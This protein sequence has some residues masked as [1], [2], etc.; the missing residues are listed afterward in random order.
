MTANPARSIYSLFAAQ[1]A[2]PQPPLPFLM[3]HRRTSLN[4]VRGPTVEDRA[5]ELASSP[6]ACVLAHWRTEIVGLLEEHRIPADDNRVN[7][8]LEFRCLHRNH[9]LAGLEI[10]ALALQPERFDEALGV[11]FFDPFMRALNSTDYKMDGGGSVRAKLAHSAMRDRERSAWVAVL[12]ATT[13]A[14]VVRRGHAEGRRHLL[15]LRQR[16]RSLA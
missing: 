2:S 12:R 6:E 10:V 1:S 13:V 8:L 7:T 16:Q 4:D 15:E 14:D 11:E 3:A 5:V 9:F